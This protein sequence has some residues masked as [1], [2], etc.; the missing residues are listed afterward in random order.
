MCHLRNR[1][2]I[3]YTYGYKSWTQL[4]T[5]MS[6]KTKFK[7]ELACHASDICRSICEV[8]TA[9]MPLYNPVCGQR[10]LIAGIF[11]NIFFVNVYMKHI[12]KAIFKNF[13]RYLN[14]IQQKSPQIFCFASA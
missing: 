11:S 5:Q 2:D 1:R 10:A 3:H 6:K 8:N 12:A 7:M 13:Q 9:A 14:V 4:K